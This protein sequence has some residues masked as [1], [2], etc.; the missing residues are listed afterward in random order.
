[1][2]AEIS[3]CVKLPLKEEVLEELVQKAKDWA[4]MHGISM[5]SKDNF[6]PDSVQIAPFVLF[7][8]VLKRNDFQNVVN[9]QVTMNE[10]VHKISHDKEFLTKC[11][12]ETITV[13]DFTGNLFKIYE[14]VENE[15][16]TQKLALGLLRSDYMSHSKT[17]NSPKQV[18]LN[19]IASSLAGIAT[20]VSKLNRYIYFL[21]LNFLLRYRESVYLMIN[22]RL[23]N[24]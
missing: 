10:L 21:L 17:N 5:R 12:K 6:N 23:C 2:C 8:T 13:D 24:L 19:T 9:I 22:T 7:P 14:I 11:L 4:N 20:A 16:V 15:G 3:P 1:M 18:E